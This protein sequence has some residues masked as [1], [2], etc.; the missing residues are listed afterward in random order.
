[1]IKISFKIGGYSAEMTLN[2]HML[3]VKISTLRLRA[4]LL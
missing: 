4:A 3:L 2:R 1:M